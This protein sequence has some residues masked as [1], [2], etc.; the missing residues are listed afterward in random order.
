MMPEF[1]KDNDIFST[2]LQVQKINLVNFGVFNLED[3][4]TGE[5]YQLAQKACERDFSR[6]LMCI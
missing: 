2:T 5:V 4:P 3:S 1:G 6:V